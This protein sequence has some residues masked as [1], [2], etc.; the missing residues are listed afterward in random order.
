MCLQ[1]PA[2]IKQTVTWLDLYALITPRLAIPLPGTKSKRIQV[3]RNKACWQAVPSNKPPKTH[4]G[5]LVEIGLHIYGQGDL[6]VSLMEDEFAQ[7]G[8][9]I[10]V[11]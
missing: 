2:A 1:L 4:Y 11:R 5:I 6:S 7:R 10:H 8:T 9:Q 3:K